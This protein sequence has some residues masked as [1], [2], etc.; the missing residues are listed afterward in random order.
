MCGE[1]G[2]GEEDREGARGEKELTEDIRY[3]GG[4][5][6]EDREGEEEEEI[7]DNRR[8]GVGRWRKGVGVNSTNQVSES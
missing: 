4:E 6:K 8:Y 1:G 5:G 3:G 2:E 7:G